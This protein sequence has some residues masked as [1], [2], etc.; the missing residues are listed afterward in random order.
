MLL[1]LQK[2]FVAALRDGDD[3]PLRGLVAAPSYLPGRVEIYRNT[4]Q[5]SLSEILRAAF[6]V[7]ERIVGAAF[8]TA[9]ARAFV[10]AA[11]PRLPQLSAYGDGFATFVST[12][13][14]TRG[15]PY[16]ADV[17]RLEW[18]RNESYFAA[19][20]PAL[21]PAMLETQGD[22]VL[23]GLRPQ[24]HPATRIVSSRFPIVRIWQVNQ[25]EVADVPVVDMSVAESALVTRRDGLLAVRLLSVGDVAF[26]MTLDAGKPLDDAVNAA[27]AKEPAFDVQACL[28]AH[29]AGG[30]FRA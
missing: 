4:V 10:A 12:F 14:K 16:L 2:K 13:E 26:V 19:D 8:F 25:P 28:F 23:P 27:F 24:M 17:A 15:L 22:D 1:E 5:G 29:L 6:P 11:P 21:D 20:V 3:A 9:M 7:V 30:T 18:A